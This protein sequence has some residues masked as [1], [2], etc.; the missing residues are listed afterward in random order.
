MNDSISSQDRNFK[1]S[2][3]I[4]STLRSV[5]SS[6]FNLVMI[7]VLLGF[8]I[9]SIFVYLERGLDTI[10]MFLLLFCAA[11]LLYYLWIVLTRSIE[12]NDVDIRYKEANREKVIQWDKIES[13]KIERLLGQINL[14]LDGERIRIHTYG[15]DKKEL[16]T[17]NAIIHKHAKTR[18][19]PIEIKRL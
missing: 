5:L 13:I 6:W 17:L 1:T 15:L 3:K 14:W 12:V 2:I 8:C 18:E 4:S 11:F 7:F 9:Q 19:I 16:V 10:E